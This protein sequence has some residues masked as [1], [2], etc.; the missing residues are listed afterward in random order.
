MLL[1]VCQITT[2]MFL[3]VHLKIGVDKRFIETKNI[4]LNN[5]N[6]FVTTHPLKG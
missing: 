3:K 5:S 1:I 4:S 6:V 2:N